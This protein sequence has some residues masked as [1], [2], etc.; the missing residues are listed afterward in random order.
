MGHLGWDNFRIDPD[1]CS[2]LVT[3]LPTTVVPTESQ[4]IDGLAQRCLS[5]SRCDTFRH[6]LVYQRCLFCNRVFV[7][8]EKC[9]PND[10]MDVCISFVVPY[11]LARDLKRKWM[12]CPI[13]VGHCMSGKVSAAT[14]VATDDA[15]P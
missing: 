13:I 6:V 9:L 8:L 15:D 5:R 10:A 2:L 1:R 12:S 11:A 7:S 4:T 14:Y 3:I